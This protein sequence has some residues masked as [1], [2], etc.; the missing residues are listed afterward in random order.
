MSPGSDLH[1]GFP[2]LMIPAPRS[3]PPY[4]HPPQ[5]SQGEGP[6]SQKEDMI[7]CSGQWDKGLEIWE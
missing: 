7:M 4:P 5:G 2:V 6:C 1:V 3:H